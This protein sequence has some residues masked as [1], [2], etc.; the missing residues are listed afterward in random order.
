[1]S[2]NSNVFNVSLPV[3]QAYSLPPQCYTSESYYLTEKSAVFYKTWQYV[4]YSSQLNNHGDYFTWTIADQPLVFVNNNGIIK[5]HHNACRHRGSTLVEGCGK[6]ANF[7]CPYHGWTY[8]LDGKLKGCPEF[9]GVENFERENWP[10]GA[11]E[12]QKSG[13]FIFARIK[14]GIDDLQDIVNP[15]SPDAMPNY[16]FVERRKYNINCNWKVFVDNYLDGGYH[17][18]YVHE[19]L[20]ACL[21]YKEY[22]THVY[23]KSVLQTAPLSGNLEARSDG[24]AYYWWFYPN[25]MVN[26][27][28]QMMD[29]NV[30]LP[31]SVNTC[32]VIIDF[33][34]GQ[35]SDELVKKSLEVSET[36]QQE[37]VAICERVQRGIKSLGYG[38]S[39]YSVQREAGMYRF[40]QLVSY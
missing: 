25:L 1:M 31:T 39:R 14:D 24:D 35:I 4:G 32:E 11:V 2:Y 33:F 38:V 29:V 27:Y 17:V 23:N 8:D 26:I 40:H 10:L 20:A 9:G 6:V 36:I 34:K 13:P 7:R 3:E 28:G 18:N 22:K 16:Q 15:F 37:D 30:V 19:G 21:D 12:V 5:G